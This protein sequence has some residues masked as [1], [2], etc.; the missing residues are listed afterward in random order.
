MLGKH[1]GREITV[2][3]AYECLAIK[4]PDVDGGFQLHSGAFRDRLDES[5]TG[6]DD[7]PDTGADIQQ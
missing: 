4:V 2:E 6:L 1:D 3:H 7:S 5:E